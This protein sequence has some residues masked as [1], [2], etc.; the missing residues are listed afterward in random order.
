M[1]DPVFDA[2]AATDTAAADRQQSDITTEDLT[3]AGRTYR[4]DWGLRKGQ[5]ILHLNDPAVTGATRVFVA[6]GEGS[7]D[8]KFIGGARYTVHNVAPGPGRISIWVDVAW[9][10]PINLLV[11][12]LIVQP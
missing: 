6:A 11:D 10:S 4:H 7:G 8:G 1:T 9:D 12:Y 2:A 5:W 3:G